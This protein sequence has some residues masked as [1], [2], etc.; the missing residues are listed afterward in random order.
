MAEQK[1]L[2]NL[3]GVPTLWARIK[4]YFALKSNIAQA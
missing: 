3:N 4:E 1:F 2:D